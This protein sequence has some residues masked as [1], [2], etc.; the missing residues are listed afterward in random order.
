[1]S[2]AQLVVRQF[3]FENIS[4][5][6]NPASAF[7][8]FVFPLLFLVI[9]TTIFSGD[10][11]TPELGRAINSA[12]YYT[13]SILAFGVISACYTNIAISVVFARDEGLL[14][15]VRGT[16]MPGWAYLLSKVVHAVF[17]QIL[18][19]VITVTFGVLAYDVS[20]PT[21][22]IVPF[23]VTLVV[24][25]AAF[26][27]LGLAITSV[28]PNFDA[29]PPIVNVTVLPLLFISGVFI[30]VEAAPEWLT[31]IADIF[32]VKHFLDA[33]FASYLGT[34]DTAW[35]GS[36]LLITGIW[37]LAGLALATRFFSWEPRR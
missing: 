36:D 30:P 32:P 2:G 27:S 11:A 28:I 33:L 22:T 26:C 25:A 3:R 18:L 23:T 7:F 14:K 34:P 17:V 19:V 10:A 5:W 21:D 4:F 1:M 16:P 8:T 24:G 35:Q 12:T 31:T 29:A 13:A 37:A 15:R 6:R 20:V 9:F